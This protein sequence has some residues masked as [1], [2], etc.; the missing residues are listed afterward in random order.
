MKIILVIATCLILGTIL[1]GIRYDKKG[2]KGNTSRLKKIM[3]LNLISV[4]G[5]LA[6]ILIPNLVFAASAQTAAPAS[7]Q[8]SNGLAYIGAAL[9]TGLACIGSGVAVGQAGSAAI[10]A[11]SEDSSIMGKTMIILGLA[12]GIAIYGL[13][14]SIMIL[15]SL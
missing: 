12:E 9:S 2:V 5:L 13:I 8:A 1:T 14:I 7:A 6:L 3:A 4:F 10:G 15:V 11:I